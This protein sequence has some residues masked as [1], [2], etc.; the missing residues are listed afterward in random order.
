MT[1]LAGFGHKLIWLLLAVFYQS[2]FN[3]FWLYM[4]DRLVVEMFVRYMVPKAGVE[5]ARPKGH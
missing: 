4:T 3:G 2:D 5:P 1:L